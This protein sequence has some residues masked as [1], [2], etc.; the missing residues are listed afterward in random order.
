ME[1]PD[2][3]ALLKYYDV[4]GKD[5]ESVSVE[6]CKILRKRFI[7]LDHPNIKAYDDSYVIRNYPFQ[8][9]L[10]MDGWKFKK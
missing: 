4:F 3:I 5:A 1:K 6:A 9:S 8:W 10:F 7:G 2:P